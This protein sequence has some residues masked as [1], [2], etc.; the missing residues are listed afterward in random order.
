MLSSLAPD[1]DPVA[2]LI[3]QGILH[4][5]QLEKLQKELAL[6]GLET[7]S[8]PIGGK[9]S[10][11]PESADRIVL[12]GRYVQLEFLG[13]GGMARVYK[14][15]DP[16]LGRTVALKFVNVEDPQ[17][18]H[19]L[20]MEARS[21]AR[22]EQEHVCKIYEAGEVE[23]KPYIAMQYIA[24]LNV[25]GIQR[26]FSPTKSAADEG[27]AAVIKG[28]YLMM[29]GRN[30]QDAFNQ[31]EGAYRE[32]LRIHPGLAGAYGSQAHVSWRRGEHAVNIKA[33]PSAD[34]KAARSAL[35][36]CLAADRSNPDCHFIYGQVE[37]VAARWKIL[38]HSSPEPEF[39]NALKW[40]NRA[41]VVTGSYPNTEAW[42]S[43]A[44]LTRYW[45]E[46]KVNSGQKCG[47]RDPAWA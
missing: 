27:S 34:L 2:A 4:P 22:V 15:F 39:R 43:K 25:E 8:A 31:A 1:Q 10:I 16:S 35:D 17:L 20:L 45:A 37:L 40:L 30:P 9:D 5:Q 6:D 19:R 14:A 23:G 46:W 47:K 28:E 38:Q 24:G 32:V 41:L 11:S 21:Q 29:V 42:M 26:P 7:M 36:Q 3:E 33:D 13:Q 44:S 12:F 18:A